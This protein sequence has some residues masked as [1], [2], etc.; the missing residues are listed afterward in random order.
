MRSIV[1][2]GA[3][4]MFSGGADIRE[5]NTPKANA[6]PTLHTLIRMVEAS[7]KPVSVHFVDVFQFKDGNAIRTDEIFYASDLRS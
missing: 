2:A 6:E 1:I 5:F 3:G 4:R 7:D